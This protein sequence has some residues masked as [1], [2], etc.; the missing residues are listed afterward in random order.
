MNRSSTAPGNRKINLCERKKPMKNET[1]TILDGIARDIVASE[2]AKIDR[3]RQLWGDEWEEPETFSDWMDRKTGEKS[4]TYSSTGFYELT[5][6]DSHFDAG[7]AHAAFLVESGAPSENEYDGSDWDE[8]YGWA[9]DA[10]ME[11]ET[12]PAYDYVKASLEGLYKK[13]IAEK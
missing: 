11:F 9:S 13:M 8:R 10:A 4:P 12:G 5:N 6:S 3:E 7:W 1:K 2:I